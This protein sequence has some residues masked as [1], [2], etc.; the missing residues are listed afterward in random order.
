MSQLEL[1]LNTKMSNLNTKMSLFVRV[2]EHF[3]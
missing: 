1:D 3:K 2:L